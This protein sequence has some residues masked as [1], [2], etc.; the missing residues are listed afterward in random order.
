MAPDERDR[1]FDKALARHLRS[2][3][4]AGET[5]RTPA[6]PGSQGG[7]CP[8]SETL[9]AYHER[10]LFPAQ[11]NSLKEHIVGCAHCQTILSQLEATDAIPLQAAEREE[12]FAKQPEP[13]LAAAHLETARAAEAAPPKKSRRVLLLRG[14]RWQWLAPAGAIA[15]SL[16]VWIA[17]HENR[18]LAPPDLKQVQVATNQVPPPPPPSISTVPQAVSPSAKDAAKLPQSRADEFA[19]ANARSVSGA[20]KSGGKQDHLAQASPQ[21]PLAD[22]EYALRKDTGRESSN[23]LLRAEEQLDRDAKTAEGARQ[24]SAPAQAQLRAQARDVQSQNQTVTITPKPPGPAPLG[25]METK[26]MKAASAAPAPSASPQPG[27]AGGIA[28]SYDDSASLEVA[29]AMTNPRL[30]SPPG[31]N[32]IWRVGRNG[33]I[34]FSKDGG[35]SWSRQISGVLADLLTGYAPSD[36]VCWIVG[37]VGSI[38]LTTDGGAHWKLVKSPLSEDLGGVRATDVLRAT[39]WNAR[40]TRSFETSDGGLTWTPVPSP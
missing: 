16:L 18:V 8:D 20:L 33:L 6:V 2:T 11:L 13:L 3:A 22:K 5:V 32:L 12:A 27:V 1:S 4:P 35:S 29:R 31:S 36:Q 21:K 10:S 19:G 40:N 15:A 26:K 24:E 14:T 23:D 7:E 38:L 34:E 37:R 39:I 28:S 17:L 9:A 30:I 25:Q